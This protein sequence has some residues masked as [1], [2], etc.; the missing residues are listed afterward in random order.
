MEKFANHFGYNRMF[1]KD[2]LTLGVHIPIENYQFHAPTMEKQVELVQ[3]A[4]Q[5]G[6]TGVWLRDVLLQDPDLV[7]LQQVKFTI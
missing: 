4:E 3:K 1:A 2:Q 5:Y 6:F 7:I